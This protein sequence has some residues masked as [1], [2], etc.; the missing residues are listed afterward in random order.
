MGKG[1]HTTW[2]TPIPCIDKI[3]MTRH[4]NFQNVVSNIIG[5]IQQCLVQR[6]FIDIFSTQNRTAL[7]NIM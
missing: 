2:F 5:D 7:S 6:A 4:V 3:L 1:I